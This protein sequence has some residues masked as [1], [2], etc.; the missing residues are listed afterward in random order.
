MRSFRILLV[1]IALLFC[2]HTITAAPGFPLARRQDDSESTSVVSTTSESARP[3]STPRPREA[4]GSNSA[5]DHQSTI[6]ES[7]P[8]SSIVATTTAISASPSVTATSSLTNGTDSGSVSEDALP[9]HPKITPALG[10]IGAIFLIS[11]VLYAVIGIKN[12]WIYVFGSAAYLAS[13]AVTGKSNIFTDSS[14]L[15]YLI[16]C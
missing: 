6:G 10:L 16:Q 9:L 14:K 11:G 3:S 8:R 2:L 4:S 12:K 7:A 15:T 13:L 1:T 5:S